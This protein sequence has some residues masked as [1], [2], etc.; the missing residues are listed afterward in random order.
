MGMGDLCIMQSCVNMVI[1]S[2]TVTTQAVSGTH[3][4]SAFPASAC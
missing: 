2:C 1:R 3:A 4:G